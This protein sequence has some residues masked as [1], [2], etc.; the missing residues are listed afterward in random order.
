[1]CRLLTRLRNAKICDSDS[2][3][4]TNIDLGGK[5][6]STVEVHRDVCGFIEANLHRY[7]IPDIIT[8]QPRVLPRP[9]NRWK[10]V[11]QDIKEE[12]VNPSIQVK[13]V[14]A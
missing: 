6:C 4:N 12:I 10:I 9:K 8:R 11:H 2:V 13:V 3:C 5:S 1:M 14:V 7:T